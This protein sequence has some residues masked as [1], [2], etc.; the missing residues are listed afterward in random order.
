MTKQEIVNYVCETPG[1]TNPAVLN[2]M[3]DDFSKPVIIHLNDY[4]IDLES[5]IY[6]GETSAPLENGSEIFAKINRAIKNNQRVLI[7]ANLG[8]DVC[9]APITTWTWNPER[10][11]Y[12]MGGIV[13]GHTGVNWMV[14]KVAISH[15]GILF[16]LM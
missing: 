14:V 2:S 11:I 3:L 15:E 6:S 9:Y 8:R 13:T 5:L 7:S 4:N 16:E 10:E 12:Y 1:N